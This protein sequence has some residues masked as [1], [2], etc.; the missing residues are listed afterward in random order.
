[1]NYLIAGTNVDTIFNQLI[2]EVQDLSVPH[3]KHEGYWYREESRNGN[4]ITHS[5]PVTVAY[6]RPWNRVL[7]HTERDAN[8][9]FHLFESMWMLAGSNA[10]APMTHYVKNFDKYS[11]DGKTLNGAYGYRWRTHFGYD[12]LEW[13]IEELKHNPTSRRC[14]LQ[15]WDGGSTDGDYYHPAGPSPVEGSGDLYKALHGS[16]DVPCNTEVFFR[17]VEGELAM[18][19]VNRSNDM[20]LGMLGANVVHFSFLQEYVANRIGCGIGTYYQITNN[21]HVYENVHSLEL[22]GHWYVRATIEGT[23]MPSMVWPY[24]PDYRTDDPSNPPLIG[25]AEVTQGRFDYE[26]KKLV[27]EYADPSVVAE[28]FLNGTVRNSMRAYNAY[29]VQDFETALSYCHSIQHV[30]WRRACTNWMLRR[31]ERYQAKL[32]A[33][34]AEAVQD[35]DRSQGVES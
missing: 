34:E 16:R 33:S 30:Q 24:Q 29:R 18:T 35:S 9:F 20:I 23:G 31:Q 5:Q 19:V 8:P 27:S 21:L 25:K 22:L 28:P 2:F 15:M 1:V 11:D 14:V 7:Y 10:L 26:V 12:Q 32:K 13:I 17:I 3:S 6:T 4:V